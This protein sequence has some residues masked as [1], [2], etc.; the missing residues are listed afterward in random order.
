MNKKII[1]YLSGVLITAFL[2]S[3]DSDL[4]D[5]KSDA[6]IDKDDIENNPELA[7]NLFLGSYLDLH[8][9]VLNIDDRGPFYFGWNSLCDEGMDNAPVWDGANAYTKPQ[10]YGYGN[11]FKLN[12]DNKVY[13]PYKEINRLNK[14]IN[15]FKDSEDPK[16]GSTVGEAYFLRAFHYFEMARRFGGVPL[17]SDD[18]KNYERLV[19][20]TEKETWDYIANDLDN[21]AKLLIA[22]QKDAVTDKDRANKYTAYALKSR[23]ML[24][25]GT[26]AK[27]GGGVE[28]EG[29]QGINSSEANKYFKLAYAAADSVVKST[30]YSLYDDYQKIFLDEN[31][32]EVIF[33]I[34]QEFPGN[35]HSYDA[36]MAPYRFRQ[37]WGTETVPFLEMAESYEYNDGIIR[38]FDYDKKYKNVA[39]MF[40]NKDLRLDATILR[41]DADWLGSKIQIHRETRVI[42][43][44]GETEKYY[45]NSEWQLTADDNKV[46]GVEGIVATGIDGPINVSG[47]WDITRTG[48]YIKKYLDP[49]KSNADGESWQNQILIRYGEILLNKAEAA[50]ELGGSTSSEGLVA[51]NEVRSRAGLPEKSSLDIDVIRHERKIE[52]AF[53]LHR[54]WDLRRWR[55]GQDVLNNRMFHAMN[56]I[57]WVDQTKTPSEIYFT[58]E[59][60]APGDHLKHRLYNKRDNYCPLPVGSNPG[61]KQNLGW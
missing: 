9:N 7:Q 32:S 5:V 55:I 2:F 34:D 49:D 42:K 27:Y 31:N 37:G 48:L 43:A 46:P 28:N 52:L 23:A 8:K 13:W 41:G 36:N 26:I 59:K 44:S 58:V 33:Q 1:Y 54:F 21:A 53:E 18:V 6:I 25:A 30:K 10:G 4:L 39:E 40:D 17:I 35:G 45:V 14:F 38:P 19:R 20:N 29:L 61:M 3:C 50:A 11:A 15:D 57:Q 60:V 22:E 16:I 24:Y 47:G 12:Q 51:L 56:P